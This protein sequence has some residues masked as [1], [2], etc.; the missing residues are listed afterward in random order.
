[1]NLIPQ[2]LAISNGD[3]TTED[4]KEHAQMLWAN[5]ISDPYIVDNEVV[6]KNIDS[7]ITYLEIGKEHAMTLMNAADEVN[8]PWFVVNGHTVMLNTKM[9]QSHFRKNLNRE[10]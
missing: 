10:T 7:L 3:L 5:S 4:V 2:L 1:M 6:F 9:G 8:R